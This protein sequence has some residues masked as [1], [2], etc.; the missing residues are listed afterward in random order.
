[1]SY[2][3]HTSST[4]WLRNILSR[5][6]CSRPCLMWPGASYCRGTKVAYLVAAVVQ[7]LSVFVKLV[8]S[9]YALAWA[10]IGRPICLTHLGLLFRSCVPS[11]SGWIRE[12]M[13]G[14]IMDSVARFAARPWTAQHGLCSTSR[15]NLAA[16]KCPTPIL[17]DRSDLCANVQAEAMGRP[18]SVS[19]HK[20]IGDLLGFCFGNACN[21]V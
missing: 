17:C 2:Q 18:G 11:F 19:I 12:M 10:W 6:V 1:M 5:L 4:S 8:A 9:V 14:A 3:V 7:G 20:A 13:R 21:S 15:L 16:Q